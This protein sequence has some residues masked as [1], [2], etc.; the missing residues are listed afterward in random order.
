MGFFLLR[1]KQE[2]YSDCSALVRVPTIV[3]KSYLFNRAC[4]DW[5]IIVMHITYNET[6]A[7]L[8]VSDRA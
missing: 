8:Q 7:G 4:A 5:K 1:C 2:R 6:I 3:Q